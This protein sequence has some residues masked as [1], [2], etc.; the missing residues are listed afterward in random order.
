MHAR[1]K[2]DILAYA[3]KAQIDLKKV[4]EFLKQ[5]KL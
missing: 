4:S 5:M 1:Q 3:E 2:A